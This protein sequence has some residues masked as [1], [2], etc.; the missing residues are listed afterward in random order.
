MKLYQG[1]AYWGMQQ[2]AYKLEDPLMSQYTWS[3]SLRTLYRRQFTLHKE[4]EAAKREADDAAQV[5]AAEY[6]PYKAGDTVGGTF[7]QFVIDRIVFNEFTDD[8][9]LYSTQGVYCTLWDVTLHNGKRVERFI[10]PKQH[11]AEQIVQYRN[12]AGTYE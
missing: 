1:D 7:K 12:Q 2:P 11:T 5:W 8:I 9:V 6:S 4:H 10:D 3:E